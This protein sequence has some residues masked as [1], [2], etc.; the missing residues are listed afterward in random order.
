MR[1]APMVLE[2]TF[3]FH[4]GWFSTTFLPALSFLLSTG[5]ACVIKGSVNKRLCSWCTDNGWLTAIDGNSRLTARWCD[6]DSYSDEKLYFCGVLRHANSSIRN[7]DSLD[8][9]MVLDRVFVFSIQSDDSVQ[10]STL[11]NQTT[12]KIHPIFSNVRFQI[13]TFVI[14]DAPQ[15]YVGTKWQWEDFCF[16]SQFHIIINKLYKWFWHVIFKLLLFCYCN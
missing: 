8:V 6:T 4:L 9:L 7:E 2:C 14:R 1:Q 15:K 11:V 12:S 3:M 16:H 10:S 5:D 13:R